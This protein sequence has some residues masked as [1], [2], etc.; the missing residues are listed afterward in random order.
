M[1]LSFP[2]LKSEVQSPVKRKEKREKKASHTWKNKCKC[3]IPT[4][5]EEGT[6]AAQLNLRRMGRKDSLSSVVEAVNTVFTQ[7]SQA[8]RSDSLFLSQ[9]VLTAVE[10]LQQ[11]GFGKESAS[12]AFPL[13]HGQQSCR[14]PLRRARREMTM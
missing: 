2:V 7:G 1:S 11:K 8:G 10:S 12:W 3:I 9:W 4:I 14:L 6:R 5:C 13:S